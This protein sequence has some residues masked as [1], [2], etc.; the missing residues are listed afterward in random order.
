MPKAGGEALGGAP[1]SGFTVADGGPLEVG[2]DWL[3]GT[4]VGGVWVVVE[5]ANV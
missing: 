1:L 5:L 3:V 4:V 2:T